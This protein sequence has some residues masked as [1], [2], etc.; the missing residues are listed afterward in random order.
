[1]SV[2]IA[3]LVLEYVKVLVWPTVLVVLMIRYRGEVGGLLKKMKSVTTPAGSVEFAEEAQRL[4]EAAE[5]APQLAGPSDGDR[6]EASSA[7]R[8]PDETA[9]SV[10]RDI[11]HKAPEAAVMGAWRHVETKLRDAV[12]LLEWNRDDA[13]SVSRPGRPR[14]ASDL[15]TVLAG[16]GLDPEWT[17]LLRDLQRMRNSATH[18]DDVSPSAAVDY[19]QS[20]ELAV[21]AVDELINITSLRRP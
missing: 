3:E 5:E 9:F 8:R 20:C 18:L 16:H 21:L 4:R 14:L 13:A 17:R 2:E 6:G 1:V 15:I 19:V 7:L 12:D 11:A 10:Y